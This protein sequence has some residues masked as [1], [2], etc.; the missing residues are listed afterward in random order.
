MEHLENTQHEEEKRKR[1][2][3]YVYTI[4]AIALVGVTWW[5]IYQYRQTADMKVRLE[6]QYNRSFHELVDY[7]D[8]IQTSLNKGMLVSSPAQMASVSGEIFRKSTAAKAC[9]G[10]L[11][12]SDVQLENTS[13][14]LSQ[15]GDYTYVLSQNMIN[16]EKITEE[17][18]NNLKSLSS[19]AKTLNDSLLK[20]QGAVYS[21]DISFGKIAYETKRFLG[22]QD[23]KAADGGVL[24]DLE[25]VE[26]EFQEYPSLIYDGPFS[27]HIENMKPV[28]LEEAAEIDQE[29][30]RQKA[31]AFLGDENVKFESDVQNNNMDAYSFTAG[32]DGSTSVSLTKKG[33]Y[34]IYYI[35]DR[36]VESENMGFEQATQRAQEFLS[37]KGFQN[38]KRSYYDKGENIATINFAYEQNGVTCYSDLIKVRVALDNGEILGMESRGYIMNHKKR[39]VSGFE[40]SEAQAREK[41]SKHLNI[42]RVS[43]ALV[44]KD[45][46]KEVLCYEFQGKFDDKNFLIYINAENGREEKILMLIESDDGVLTV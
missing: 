31:A 34:V 30:A 18:Y 9:L 1:I 4:L 15:V 26:K 8:D 45:S 28:M 37:A 43:K 42:E 23:A 39:D 35:K 12:V 16:D 29:T 44:P 21:G 40:L 36:L 10:Q 5:G 32:D 14:F 24:E 33:G 46:M 17:E 20:M 27:E 11:P 6:N 13:K 25:K 7:V 2:D 41:I 3:R 38:L 19:Y 22:N